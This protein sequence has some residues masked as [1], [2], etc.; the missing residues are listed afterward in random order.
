MAF[1]RSGVQFPL[2]PPKEY[3][4][5]F[6]L[7]NNNITIIWFRRDLRLF[8]NQALF[9]A[10]NLGNSVLPIYI[11]DPSEK[12]GDASKVWLYKSLESLQ[13]SLNGFLSFYYGDTLEILKTLTSKY[14]ISSVFWNK[15]YEPDLLTQENLIIKFL[16]DKGLSYKACNSSLLWSPEKILKQDGTPYK[17]FTYFYQNGCLKAS[18]PRMAYP[19]PEIKNLIVDGDAN[20]LNNAIKNT[21]S[22]KI[23][24][25]WNVGE[26]SAIKKLE[27]FISRGLNGYKEGR[28]YPNLNS[29]SKLS[30]HIHFGE[31]SIHHIWH[32]VLKSNVNPEDKA[33]FLSELGWREF[34]HHLLY[35]F[36]DIHSV[37]MQSKFDSF[38][39][40]NNE[41]FFQAWTKGLTGYPIIDAG[42]RELWETGYM[43]NRVR[44]IVGSFLV[45]NLLIDWRYGAK[46]FWNCLL[47]AD[48]ANNS[49]SWQWVA[50]CGVD[51]APYFRIF[52]PVLQGNKFDPDGLYTKRFVPELKN[53][54][55]KYLF[56][57]FDAPR[58]I[59]EDANINL[60]V[61]YPYPIVNLSESKYLALKEFSKIS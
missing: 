57:P 5:F 14:N 15:C 26:D 25:Y 47:D 55:N 2:A 27:A 12:I 13:K 3:S 6:M 8:D 22:D 19:K 41:K 54:P 35:H 33:C 37:N 1:K 30:T 10:S 29:T 58:K 44:M 16:Q 48:L 45:K 32:E 36:R 51:S 23:M 18:Q 49:T 4:I 17:I 50:G 42:M 52:N 38:R 31:I 20:L 60:G 28:N 7:G 11:F 24:Q 53:I 61:N 21:W 59:L 34:A 46:W 40:G 43:H 56:N 9:E 39:W